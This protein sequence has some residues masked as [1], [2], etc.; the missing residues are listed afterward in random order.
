MHVSCSLWPSHK[1]QQS[2]G[3]SRIPPLSG[4]TFS[5]LSQPF[6]HWMYFSSFARGGYWSHYCFFSWL[7]ICVFLHNR[8]HLDPIRKWL[9]LACFSWPHNVIPEQYEGQVC[10]R[11]IFVIKN[12]DASEQPASS[13]KCSKWFIS[14]LDYVTIFAIYCSSFTLKRFTVSSKSFTFRTF[15]RKFSIKGLYAGFPQMLTRNSL[16]MS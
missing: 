10:A 11:H 4:D 5:L 14:Y 16:K 2:V 8:H 7:S 3:G 15:T 6:P 13:G 9:R 1:Q 12:R